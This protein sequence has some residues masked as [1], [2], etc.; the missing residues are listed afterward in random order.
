ME[1]IKIRLFRGLEAKH[2][3]KETYETFVA[4]LSD[5]EMLEQRVHKNDIKF[6]IESCKYYESKVT[7][8]VLCEL[9]EGDVR[10]HVDI[11]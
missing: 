3:N 11:V 6:M 1:K 8:A 7:G 9:Y 10:N 5:M 4:A 2:T